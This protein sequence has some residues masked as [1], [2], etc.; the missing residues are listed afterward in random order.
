MI[1]LGYLY[2]KELIL[3]VLGS[4]DSKSWENVSLVALVFMLIFG[5]MKTPWLFNTHR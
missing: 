5:F 2:W 1:L 3:T 4:Q